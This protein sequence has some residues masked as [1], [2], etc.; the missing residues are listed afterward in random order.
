MDFP[1]AP[2]FCMGSDH[3][4]IRGRSSLT[5]RVEKATKFT[6]RNHRTTVDWKLFASFVGFWKDTVRDNIDDEYERLVEHLTYEESEEF[7]NHQE[8][9]V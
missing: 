7:Q 4:L 9:P 6:K 3:L 8:T 1:V 2:K 5:W